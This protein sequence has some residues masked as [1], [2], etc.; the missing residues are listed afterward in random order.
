M[1][2][3]KKFLISY[4]LCRTIWKLS[5]K[6]YIFLNTFAGTDDEQKAEFYRRLEE[7][8][9]SL[10][11]RYTHFALTRETCDQAV[12]ALQLD[13]GVRCA[14]GNHFKYWVNQC[15]RLEELAVENKLYC[16]KNNT[17]VIS[18][19]KLFDS[20]KLCHARVGH[21]GRDKTWREVRK[22]FGWI[23][24]GCIP[25]FISTCLTCIDRAHLRKS[26]SGKV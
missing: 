11:G 4:F 21:A 15:F 3:L 17:P 10:K 25:I 22:N 19:D 12:S 14:Q 6:K 5:R 7:H 2:F 8:I 23:R 24:Y 9:Q 26:S 20:I 13:K 16:K 18:K 1:I